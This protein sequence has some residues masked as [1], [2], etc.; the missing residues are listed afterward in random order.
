[1]KETLRSRLIAFP[2]FLTFAL[3][4]TQSEKQTK[5]ELARKFSHRNRI[6]RNK[7]LWK[8]AKL[9]RKMPTR[10]MSRD[11]IASKCGLS[12][13]KVGR[14]GIRLS[15]DDVSVSDMLA[16]TEACNI[17]FLRL[18]KIKFLLNNEARNGHYFRHLTS[19]QF[20]I[21]TRQIRKVQE[22]KEGQQV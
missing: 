16:F 19:Q 7:L 14:I 3:A 6:K 21:L 20:Q 13:R 4:R 18:S 17:D 15:W 9:K 5:L 12:E 8:G 1:M 11:E 10:R 2:P 22:I